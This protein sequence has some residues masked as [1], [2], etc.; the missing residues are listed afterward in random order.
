MVTKGWYPKGVVRLRGM[1]VE[2]VS[3]V[4]PNW[5]A[6]KKTSLVHHENSAPSVRADA[7]N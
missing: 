4:N 3:V 1:A 6:G 2:Q 7:G 5:F